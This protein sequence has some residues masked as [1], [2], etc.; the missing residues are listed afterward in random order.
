MVSAE[1]GMKLFFS[2]K[3]FCNS[4]L[5]PYQGNCRQKSTAN[6]LNDCHD[7]TPLLIIR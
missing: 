6:Y 3:S 5:C 2:R 1:D 4:T 7:I